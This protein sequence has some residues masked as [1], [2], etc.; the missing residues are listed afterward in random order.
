MQQIE[1]FLT[2]LPDWAI[3][4][5]L[6]AAAVLVGWA[7]HAVAFRW[8]YHFAAE[9]IK[10][11]GVYS[12]VNVLAAS[13]PGV[14]PALRRRVKNLGRCAV[15][16]A[17]VHDRG[18]GRVLSG[19][20]REP[21]VLYEM[22]PRDLARVRR[23]V[24]ILTEIAL[25]GGAREVY[26]SILGAEPVRSVDEARR[27]DTTRIDARRGTARSNVPSASTARASTADPAPTAATDRTVRPTCGAATIAAKAAGTI[28]RSRSTPR[29]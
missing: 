20:G 14:G 3:S 21:T 13:L 28:G 2:Y 25:A 22:D 6:I 9:G 19:P 29:A 4:L 18:G 26:T 24:G 17:M 12:A 1:T 5:S 27:L 15:F 10:L 23:S 7:V 16:G 11:V 8:M